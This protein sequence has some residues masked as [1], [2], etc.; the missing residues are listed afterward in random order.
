MNWAKKEEGDFLLKASFSQRLA[1][2]TVGGKAL[3]KPEMHREIVTSHT[4]EETRS[5]GKGPWEIAEFNVRGIHCSPL[6]HEPSHFITEDK[7]VS[8]MPF[9]HGKTILPVPNHLLY[10]CRNLQ[11][12]KGR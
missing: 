4:G 2:G 6:I 3:C 10:T 8:Q 9:T 5:T 1:D 11:G 7:Q 12:L